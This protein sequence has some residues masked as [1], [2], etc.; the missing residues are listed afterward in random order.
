MDAD[1][2]VN[3]GA[4]GAII[5][6][7]IS[8]GFDDEGSQFDGEGNLRNWWSK[9]DHDK[10][11]RRVQTLVAQYG[12]YSPIEGYKINGELTLGE[13]IADNSGLPIAYKAYRI[14]LGGRP[15]PVMDGLS[16]DQ[17]FCLG[18]AQA[19]REKARDAEIVRLIQIDP[20]SPPRFRA[21]GSLSN[22]PMFYSAF[23]VKPGDKMYL[24]PE[25]RVRI[26]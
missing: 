26:W 24:P 7:E 16:G 14:A 21:N 19:W 10:F 22:L 6:H 20:H 9:A 11:K 2:A 15:A 23:A 13:N 1:D 8:H 3:Y 5:G 18:F 25:R 17:R 12:G 4:S